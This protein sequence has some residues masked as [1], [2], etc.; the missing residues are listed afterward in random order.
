MMGEYILYYRGRVFGGIY[1]NR[2]LVKHTNLLESPAYLK[3]RRRFFL[4]ISFCQ[5]IL[6]SFR[7]KDF[8]VLRLNTNHVLRF[9]AFKF[10]VK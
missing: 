7:F 4:Y 9:Q 5:D 1:D 10:P 3:G 6:Q 8:Y 2:L